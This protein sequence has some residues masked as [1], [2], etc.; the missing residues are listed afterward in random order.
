MIPRDLPGAIL[1]LLVIVFATVWFMG[2]TP[3]QVQHAMEGF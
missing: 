1:V 2:I 3:D